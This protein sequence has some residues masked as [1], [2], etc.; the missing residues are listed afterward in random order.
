MVVARWPDQHLTKG[1]L[2]LAVSHTQGLP[3]RVIRGPKLKSP[4]APTNGYRYD[5]LYAVED[6]WQDRG[7]AGFLIWRFRLR[8]SEGQPT[9][10]APPLPPPA[11]AARPMRQPSTIQRVVRSTDVTNYV[12]RLHGHQCQI[13]ATRLD[14]PAGP[15]A[16]GAHIRPLGRPHDGPDTPDNVLCLCANCHVLF[17]TGA[18]TINDNLTLKGTNGRLRAHPNHLIGVVHL[19]YHRLHYRAP[20]APRSASRPSSPVVA[21]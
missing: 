19:Q 13:C 16:E 15:Y 7:K 3:L 14:T 4:F 5:G 21:P 2:A 12:K 1:N 9:I 17:D 11:G 10:G 20:Q 8:R 18:I 6:H